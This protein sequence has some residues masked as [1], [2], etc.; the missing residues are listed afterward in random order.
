MDHKPSVPSRIGIML[1]S[2][3]FVP[4]YANRE[5]LSVLTYPEP[6]DLADDPRYGSHITEALA[7]LFKGTEDDTVELRSGRRRYKCRAF[8]LASTSRSRA[9]KTVVVSLEREPR[10]SVSHLVE[11]FHLTQRECET[12]SLLVEGLTNK[13]IAARMNIAPNTVKAFLKVV[14]IKMHVS[15]RA[16]AVGKIGEA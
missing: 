12:A 8:S 10:V 9:E 3:S 4:I 16:G 11:R 15:T 6:P 1:V 7:H 14:M 2:P 13:E 5:A